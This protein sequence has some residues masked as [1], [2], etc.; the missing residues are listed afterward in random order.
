[1]I[2]SNLLNFRTE[3]QK[4]D[5]LFLQKRIEAVADGIRHLGVTIDFSEVGHIRDAVVASL[6][7]PLRIVVIIQE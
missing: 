2:F 7:L 1:M 4:V 6:E 5:H 3:I